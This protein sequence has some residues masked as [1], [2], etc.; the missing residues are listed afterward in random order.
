MVGVRTSRAATDPEGWIPMRLLPILAFLL[1]ADLVPAA[2]AFAQT[3]DS[4]S[5]TGPSPN[6]TAPSEE[7]PVLRAAPLVGSIH[8]DGYLDEAAWQAATPVDKFTQRQ[9]DEGKPATERTEVR[10][11]IGEDALY[12]GAR[13]YDREASKIRSRL[14]R[15]D[16]DFGSDY[17]AVLLDC[18]HDGTTAVVFRVSPSGSIQ[19]ATI[20]ANGNQ[21]ASWDPVWTVHTSIDSLGWTAEMEI[22]L[23]QL[24]YAT[25]N[26]ATWGIQIRRW[27]DRKQEFSE[28]SFTPLMQDASVS[29][30]GLLEGLGHL[31]AVRHLEVLPYGLVR[32]DRTHVDPADP[33]RDGTDQSTAAGVDLRYGLT[34]NLTLNATVNP[35]FGEVEVDPAVVNLSAFETFYPEKR[36]FFIE[37]ADM[38]RFGESRSQNN[39]NS[40]IP[41]HGRRIGRAPERDISSDS[42]A[43]LDVPTHTTIASAVK[44]TGKTSSGWTIGALDAVTPVEHAEYVDTS[45]VHG[46]ANVEPLTNFFIGRVRR[47]YHQGDTVVGGMFTAVNRDL[48]DPALASLLRREAQAGGFDLNHY[49]ARR[50]WS[51][52]AMVLGS[53]VGGSQD[54]IAATQQL[55]SRY[56]QRPDN[57][58]SH[59]DPTRTSL[60]GYAGMVSLNK[61]AGKHTGGSLTYQDWSPGFE[62]NDVGF[63]N[64]V[65]SHAL[66]DLVLYKENTPHKLMRQWDT[67]A[68]SNWSWNYGGNL[69]YQEYAAQLEGTFHNYWVGSVRGELYPGSFDDKLT[70]GGPLSRVPSGGTV[71]TNWTS[72]ARK[73]YTLGFGVINSWDEAGGHLHELDVNLSLRPMTSLRVQLTP[74]FQNL[75]NNAQYVQT[76]ADSLATDTYGARYVF[77]T[78]DQKQLALDTRVDWV[79]SPKLSLQLY[80]QPLIVSGGYTELKE[81]RAPRTYEFNVYGTHTGTIT[82]DADGNSTIDPD[83]AG[84][85]APFEVSNPDFNFR[86]LRGNAVLRWEYRPGSALFLVWTQNREDTAPIGDFN[87]SRD[88]HALFD[89]HPTNMIALKATYWLPI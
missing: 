29:R 28:F 10:V 56:F 81:L 76:T 69:T 54:A 51:V 80:V 45:G 31:D 18:D 42:I 59:Y 26:D 86:S 87:A 41:F 79:F 68:F 70:R 63:M 5:V 82:R 48:E 8:I 14:V 72:D 9:P 15:R 62:I 52:D 37:G 4:I 38:F 3:A 78:L 33:F 75:R 49:F 65:D 61:I 57:D 17:L 84:P 39:F 77:A 36:P 7:R 16:D 23:S 13:L 24:H 53:H 6:V 30:Y 85:A 2:P 55:S 12:I 89:I 64:Q 46:T 35:D 66:S 43:F 83:G 58:Y 74:S 88:W 47:T 71:R 67:F 32:A 60:S 50:T 44:L 34:S 21:D 40:T 25:S 19:D 27:I 11:L 1:I 73:W 22:P 20:A